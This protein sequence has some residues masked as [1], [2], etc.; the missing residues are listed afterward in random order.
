ME[1]DI[2]LTR[3][4]LYQST[5]ITGR[6]L[7]LMPPSDK[8]KCHRV[9][10][11]ADNG[12]VTCFK[13]KK[14]EPEIEFQTGNL[15]YPVLRLIIGGSKDK[16]DKIF[17]TSGQTVRGV[18][19]KG[20]EFFKFSTDGAESLRG[21]HVEDTKLWTSG[22]YLFNYYVDNVESGYYLSPDKINDGLLLH[23]QSPSE[24]NPVLGC[25]DRQVRILDKTSVLFESFVDGPVSCLSKLQ[26][27]SYEDVMKQTKAKKI[28]YGTENGLVGELQADATVVRP[29]WTIQ[30]VRSLGAI[31]VIASHDLTKN[32]ME[33][34]IVG[35][36]DGEL[37]VFTLHSQRDMHQ[38]FSK[39]INESIQDV[40]VGRV[41]TTSFDEVV[42]ASYSGKVISFTS[43][44]LS[45]PIAAQVESGRF[46]VERA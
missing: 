11:G 15:D 34:I 23:I 25:Q 18:N 35:R 17:F 27:A 38:I 33:D 30:N 12:I 14:G 21:L 36:D 7:G 45:D 16:S 37:Q 19:K 4:D 9:V 40:E 39:C 43:E 32:G 24:Y 26:S 20:K 6:S 10:V 2:Q 46:L 44:P 5:C 41:C 13:V 29:G 28:V 22:E 8:K 1:L 31:N 3:K 42:L